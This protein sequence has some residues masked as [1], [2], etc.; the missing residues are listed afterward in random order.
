MVDPLIRWLRVSNKGYDIASCGLQL[1]SKWYVDDGTLVTNLVEDMIVLLD[2]VD[3][4][5]KW[6]GIIQLNANKCTITA[7]IHDLQAI[8]RKWD[9]DGVLRIRLAHVNLSGRPIGSLT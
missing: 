4:F 6:S 7:C 9:R 8:P 1:A 2:L 3:Q 5:N